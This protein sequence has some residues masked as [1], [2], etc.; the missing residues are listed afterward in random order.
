M[1]RTSGARN[2]DFDSKRAALLDV[3]TDFA[4]NGDLHRPSLRQF[5]LAASLSEPTLRHY[6]T[7]RQGLVIA[8]LE[9]LGQR[10]NVVWGELPGTPPSPAEA[11]QVYFRAS[12]EGL[13]EGSFVRAHAFGLVEGAACPRA[14]RAYLDHVLEPALETIRQLLEAT[15]GGP[16]EPDALRAAA[17]AALSPVL[18][19]SLHQDLLGGRAVA[20]LDSQQIV[21][22]LEDWLGSALT[23]EA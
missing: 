10:S 9:T 19:M 6:F 18:V 15:P 13:R 4:L 8:I 7:D 12:L 2:Y 16:R 14:G 23:G 21:T 17:L 11:L 3:L 1:A 5:A 20:P 22:H